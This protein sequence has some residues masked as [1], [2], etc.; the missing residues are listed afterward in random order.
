[1]SHRQTR[2][3][4]HKAN[5][6]CVRARACVAIVVVVVVWCLFWLVGM[7]TGTI[8]DRSGKLGPRPCASSPRAAS[9]LMGQGAPGGRFIGVVAG[10]SRGLRIVAGLARVVQSSA[11][12]PA[13]PRAR[14]GHYSHGGMP[15]AVSFP[16]HRVG[17]L[18]GARAD[19]AGLRGVCSV[20]MYTSSE[21]VLSSSVRG[22]KIK[23]TQKTAHE[24]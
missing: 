14:R 9:D 16:L 10:N 2:T 7:L 6:S 8:A 13:P 18:G 5:K 1:M 21:Y 22:G 19:T 20:R 3:S 24:G 4:V 11:A 12:R 23:E 15:T 17:A